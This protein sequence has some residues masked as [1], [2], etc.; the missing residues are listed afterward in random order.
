MLVQAWHNLR[1]TSS[2]CWQE[3]G[4]SACASHM[5]AEKVITLLPPA[6]FQVGKELGMGEK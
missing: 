2:C 3:K 5:C 4:L 6:S 1:E